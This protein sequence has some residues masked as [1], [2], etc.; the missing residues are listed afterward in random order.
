MSKNVLNLSPAY[1]STLG[2]D[3]SRLLRD[4]GRMVVA[5]R[6]LTKL[7]R[8]SILAR[9]SVFSDF[10]SSLIIAQTRGTGINNSDVILGYCLAVVA[11]NDWRKFRNSCRSAI[12][13]A[14]AHIMCLCIWVHVPLQYTNK[15]AVDPVQ[16]VR[17]KTGEWRSVGARHW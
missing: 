17:N 12:S 5:E 1:K 11:E 6:L 8:L 4:T 16:R 7:R 3:V 10:I 13:W 14:L 9:I 2:Q 15:K